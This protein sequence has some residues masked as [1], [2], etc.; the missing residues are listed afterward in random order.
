MTNIYDS[1]TNISAVVNTA[2]NIIVDPNIPD[3]VTPLDIDLLKFKPVLPPI[4]YSNLDFSSI[5]LQLINF[6]GANASKF[7]YNIRDFGDSNTAGMMMNLMAHMGQMLS[8]HMDSMVNELFLD[9]SQSSW[10]TY[11][12][13][14]MF[15]YK[16]ARPKAG[17]LFL[18]VVRNASSSLSASTSAYEDSSEILLSSSLERR[19]IILGQETFELFPAKLN[20]SGVFEPDYLNDL[21][22]PPL[23]TVDPADPDYGITQAAL[24]T[25]NCFALTGTTNIENFYA[26]GIA[27][28]IISLT[29]SPV[30][31]SNILVQVEDKSINIQNKVAYNIWTEIPFIS[32]AGF[33]SPSMIQTSST[34]IPYLIAPIQLSELAASQ[35][36]NGLLLPGMLMQI[37]YDN[38]ASIANYTDFLLLTVP[39]RLGII[40]SVVSQINPNSSY[41]DLLIFHPSYIY[42]TSSNSPVYSS[43]PVTFKDAFNNDVSWST[44]D[45]LYLLAS[46]SIKIP[47]LGIIKQPQVISDTQLLVA[48]GTKYADV[49]Y[50]QKNKNASNP[51]IMLPA[52]RY[53]YLLIN[54]YYP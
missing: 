28:Q 1:P 23:I 52:K 48:D 5:K 26:S 11:R 39:Y 53:Y 15:K 31:D 8:Y 9:T 18:T 25:Y 30:L 35:K 24:N 38:V 21:I 19:S 54:S 49:A 16:P 27:N 17:V 32:L 36:V 12:L 29:S 22:I 14:N 50:L 20:N 33:S 4:D 42:G 10:S 6:L 41:V 34:D 44:G 45:I 37:D 40:S 51:K 3:Y 43:I 2:G 13:L 7:G 46:K 47:G